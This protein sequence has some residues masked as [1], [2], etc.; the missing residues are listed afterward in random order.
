MQT[1]R[2][3]SRTII[4]M[5][6]FW[7]PFGSSTNRKTAMRT[8]SLLAITVLL[9]FGA[10]TSQASSFSHSPDTIVFSPQQGQTTLTAYVRCAYNGDTNQPGTTVHAWISSGSSYFS[11]DTAR[12]SFR[13]VYYWLVTYHV[14]NSAETGVASFSD[15]PRPS[16]AMT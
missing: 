5:M 2:V 4:V 15:R 1:G 13:S 11:V 6:S 14:Q 3:L 12:H 9:L 8:L 16:A 7:I 10:S